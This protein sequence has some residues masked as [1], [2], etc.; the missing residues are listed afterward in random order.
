MNKILLISGSNYFDAIPILRVL[1]IGY[2]FSG[3]FRTFSVNLLAAF[4]RIYYG[5]FISIT[6]CLAD[7]VFN[8]FFIIKFGSI[9]AAYAT[10]LVDIITAVLSFLYVIY[11]LKKEVI[12]EY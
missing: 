3:T 8:Y 5:L 10:L 12:N 7:I 4:H 11:L 9:G 1:L 2:F 6:S